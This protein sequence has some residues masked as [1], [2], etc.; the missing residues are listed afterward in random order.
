MFCFCNNS[1]DL[2]QVSEDESPN[3]VLIFM[4]D[5]GYG[6]V[7]CLISDSQILTANLDRLAAEGMSCTDAHAC[8][9]PTL[10]PL[11]CARAWGL[12]L[13]I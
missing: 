2:K 12:R 13:L 11:S 4:D 1:R 3:I 5:M 8:V 10:V 9:V 7:S 6:D